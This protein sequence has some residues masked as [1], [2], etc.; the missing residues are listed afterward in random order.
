MKY[1]K[2]II[3]S[4]VLA[5][6]A[7]SGTTQA[8]ITVVNGDF[9]AQTVANDSWGGS[10]IDTITGWTYTGVITGNVDIIADGEP[11]ASANTGK[12]AG[13]QYVVF[14]EGGSATGGTLFQTISGLTTGQLYEVS[15]DVIEMF[16]GNGNVARVTG[17]FSSSSVS[18]GSLA[19]EDLTIGDGG[20]TSTF[21]FTATEATG[22]L[23]FTDTSDGT[24]GIDTGLDNISIV[25][26]P[27]PSS[28][29]LLG[30]GGLAFMLRRRK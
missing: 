22:V 5:T 17:D 13:D 23:T 20:A 19:G 2:H 21:T 26:V 6:F 14:N 24:T 12:S 28:A 3:P 9:E 15:F 4:I 29:A 10:G 11:I 1:T 16:N 18:L 8:A 25:A 7:I 30:L 27:E